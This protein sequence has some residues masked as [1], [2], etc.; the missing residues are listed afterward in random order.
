MFGMAPALGAVHRDLSASMKGRRRLGRAAL[1]T[2]VALSLVLASGA[3][4]FVFSLRNLVTV[5][6][7]FDPE[8]VLQ[9]QVQPSKAGIRGADASRFYSDLLE[10][11]GRLPEIEAASFSM[12]TPLRSCCWWDSVQVDGFVPQQGDRMEAHLNSVSP[13]HFRVMGTRLIAGRDFRKSDTASSMPVAIVNQKFAEH[14]FGGREAIGRSFVLYKRRYGIVGIVEDTHMRDF[15]RPMP[16]TAYM[17]LDQDEDVR[18][19]LILQVRTK[20]NRPQDAA[21]LVQ[22]LVHEFNP[23]I[24]VETWTMAEEVEETL[25]MDRVLATLST[26]FAIAA[27]VLGS[28]G[29]YGSLSYSAARGRVKSEFVLLWARLQDRSVG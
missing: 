7:G 28:I 11:V 15:R 5:A 17:S 13:N 4:L 26:F 14:F 19:D 27:L 21:Q 25:V 22:K 29:V 18:G 6:P 8:R 9:A 23:M 16:P 20:S 2:Q 12:M 10:R 24:P 1:V 3:G